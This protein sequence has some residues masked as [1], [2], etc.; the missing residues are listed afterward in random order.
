VS[1][2]GTMLRACEYSLV[3][4]HLGFLNEQDVLREPLSMLEQVAGA[5]HKTTEFV[6]CL[7]QDNN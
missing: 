6:R 5:K 1:H 7:S 3:F 2:R 4:N